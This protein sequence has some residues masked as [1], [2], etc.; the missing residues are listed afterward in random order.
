MEKYINERCLRTYVYLK[1]YFTAE[2]TNG[3]VTE[4]FLRVKVTVY[5]GE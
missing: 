2:F 3:K 1:C 4:L 5:Y